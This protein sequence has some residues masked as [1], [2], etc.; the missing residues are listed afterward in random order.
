MFHIEL[1]ITKPLENTETSDSKEN[2][3]LNCHAKINYHI[4]IEVKP[5]LKNIMKQIQLALK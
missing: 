3:Y 4:I 1:E 5:F 2:M